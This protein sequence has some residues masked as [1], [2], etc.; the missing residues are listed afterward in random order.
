M[1]LSHGTVC[2]FVQTLHQHWRTIPRSES[3]TAKW[4][5]RNHDLACYPGV[6]IVLLKTLCRYVEQ[7][8]LERRVVRFRYLCGLWRIKQQQ[9]LNFCPT[10]RILAC[11]R[12]SWQISLPQHGHKAHRLRHFVTNATINV[13]LKQLK[14]V[15]QIIAFPI[16]QPRCNAVFQ[17][18]PDSNKVY[19]PCLLNVLWGDSSFWPINK[20]N[21]FEPWN[22]WGACTLFATWNQHHPTTVQDGHSC[23]T[24]QPHSNNVN[25]WFYQKSN[26]VFSSTQQRHLLWWK[27]GFAD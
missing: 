5:S 23:N 8:K 26:T 22:D 16:S 25:V 18:G 6:K 24:W 27:S 15:S 4:Y 19:R 2:P 13:F 11:L 7:L 20:S 21:T 1:L 3:C 12:M 14:S 9:K 10:M 17:M